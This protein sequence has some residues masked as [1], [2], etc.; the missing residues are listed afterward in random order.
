MIQ[1]SYYSQSDALRLQTFHEIIISITEHLLDYVVT[2][3]A[4]YTLLIL[5]RMSGKAGRRILLILL[6]VFCNT[7]KCTEVS[8]IRKV[9][10]PAHLY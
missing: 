2:S 1:H 7:I 8:K 4:Q 5:T 10:L 3:I 9:K 6:C